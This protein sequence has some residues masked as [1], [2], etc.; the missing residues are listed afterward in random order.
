[1]KSAIF[2][3]LFSAMLLLAS[4]GIKPKDV[5]PPQGIENDHFPQTYPAPE[6]L[7]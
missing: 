4:C 3:C 5:D 6:A 1:M 7:Q 2:V